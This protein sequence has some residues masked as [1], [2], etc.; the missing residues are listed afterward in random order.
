[1]IAYISY[2]PKSGRYP[3]VFWYSPYTAGFAPFEV[4]KP[5]LNA[6]YAFVGANFPATGCSEGII[7]YWFDRK[8]GIYGAEIVEWIAEEPWSDGN[9]GMVGNSSAGTVQFWVAAERPPHLRAIVASGVLDGYDD[10]I[11]LGGMLQ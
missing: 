11:S 9:I 4:A 8:E 10:W 3:S 6:G 5:F 2:Y 1:R 7:D